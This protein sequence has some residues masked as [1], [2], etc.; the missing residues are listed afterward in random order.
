[1]DAAE[2]RETEATSLRRRSSSGR[3]RTPKL[4]AKI[5]NGLKRRSS[6][7]S[8]TRRSFAGASASSSASITLG[9]PVVSTDKSATEE[10]I[11]LV[12]KQ[13][14]KAAQQIAQ[15]QAQAR[16][17]EN[18]YLQQQWYEAGGVGTYKGAGAVWDG[19]DLADVSFDG[20]LDVSAGFVPSDDRS[21][22]AVEFDKAAARFFYEVRPHFNVHTI[23]Q[24]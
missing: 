10:S 11:W 5:V 17:A 20:A 14:A 9:S 3:E 16:Q 23:T 12:R 13:Q 22:A 4:G 24:L 8:G 21:L 2:R 18:S 7:A 15:D 19:G 1:M 6:S